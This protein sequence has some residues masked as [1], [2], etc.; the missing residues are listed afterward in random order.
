MELEFS[1]N[2]ILE[3]EFSKNSIGIGTVIFKKLNFGIETFQKQKLNRNW[4]FKNSIGIGIFKE[5][6]FQ[7]TQLEKL[8]G[9]SILVETFKKLNFELE[10]FKNSI[11]IGISK[12]QSELEFQKLNWNWT[13]QKLN[14]EL[15]FSKN[16]ILVETFQKLNFGGDF[17][18]LNFGGDFQKTQP[19]FFQKLSEI[20]FLCRW[21]NC[22]RRYACS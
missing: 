17:S 16:S 3:L 8:G 7:K 11:G 20:V 15:E 18:K 22:Y 1:K 10:T 5:L 21:E 4:N 9:F 12:T 2:S 6:D 14:L 13:F 19:E